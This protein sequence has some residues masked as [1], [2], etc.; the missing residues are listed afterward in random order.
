M[1]IYCPRCGEPWDIDSL[2]DLVEARAFPTFDAARKVFASKGCGV[3]FESWGQ[4]P[5]VA[6][7]NDRTALIQAVFELGGGDIDG[8]ASDLSDAEYLGL[9]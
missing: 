4:S 2:H 7:N 5:C 3:A 9:I 6:A 8:I 1:D